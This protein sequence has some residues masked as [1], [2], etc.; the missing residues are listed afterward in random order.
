MPI[1]PENKARYP[2]DWKQ[3]SERIRFERAG[4]KCEWCGA[5]N[6]KP[7]PITGGM[8]TL[9][10]AHYPDHDPA[11][12]AEDNLHALCNQCHNAVD[13]PVRAMNRIRSRNAILEA[14]GQKRLL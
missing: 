3:I 10:V 2:S 1:K 9:T 11:N 13:A 12:C 14:A 8:V 5:E 7:H 4:N 6:Y